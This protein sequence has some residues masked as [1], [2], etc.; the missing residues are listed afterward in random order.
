M[1]F[2]ARLR[3]YPR[4]TIAAFLTILAFA[5]P[6][7]IQTVNAD[8]AP[9]ASTSKKCKKGYKKVK[10]KCKKKAAKKKTS[11]IVSSVTIRITDSDTYTLDVA[12]EVITKTPQTSFSVK[13]TVG[14]GSLKFPPKL[15]TATGDGVSNT[16]SYTAQTR[17]PRTAPAAPRKCKLTVEASADGVSSG[18]VS[19]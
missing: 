12:G 8:A 17:N 9:S 7:V 3:T 14:C 6:A 16:L 15:V 2:S 18:E 5:I 4:V 10:G 19:G 1:N 13:V 11:A